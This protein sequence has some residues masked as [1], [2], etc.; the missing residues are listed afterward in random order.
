V[1]LIRIK[2]SDSEF[3]R[4][5]EYQLTALY[6][7]FDALIETWGKIL[8]GSASQH[9]L[10]RSMAHAYLA[11]R[12]R[13]WSALDEH[14]L[15]TIAELSEMNLGYDPT[16]EGDLRTWLQAYRLLPEFSYSEAIDRLQSWA[17]RGNSV[18]SHYYLYILHF[19]RWKSGGERDEELIQKHLRKS[20]EVSVGRRD[21]SYEWFAKEPRWCPLVNSR[22]LGG[23]LDQKSFFRDTTKLA[24]VEGTISS[25]KKASG[26]IRIGEV[27]RAFFVPPSHIRESEHIN[28][29]VHFVLGFSYERL[30]AWLVDL[31][32]APTLSVAVSSRK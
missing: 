10:R 11:R 29:Q 19:L 16:S 12:G 27:T 20:A 31:G 17:G 25:I 21:N 23:W 6:G 26:T 18:E 13:L 1:R 24:F 15:R 2:K 32:P 14:D 4:K 28:A 30:N 22:E 3:E 9:W 7:N 8:N 5:C